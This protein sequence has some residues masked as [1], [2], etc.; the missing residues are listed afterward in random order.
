MLPIGSGGRSWRGARFA[1]FAFGRHG[2][3]SILFDSSPVATV[4]A[5]GLRIGPGIPS[6]FIKVPSAAVPASAP[7]SLVAVFPRFS[8]ISTFVSPYNLLKFLF[9]K[10]IH[11]KSSSKKFINVFKN[12]FKNFCKKCL[13]TFR[14]KFYKK[15]HYTHKKFF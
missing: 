2:A 11:H 13:K 15:V 6:I 7:T 10:M 4:G 5:V 12:F 8:R 1:G 9:L 14:K 3:F